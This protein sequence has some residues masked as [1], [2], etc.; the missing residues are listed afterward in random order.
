[1]ESAS[2]EGKLRKYLLGDVTP[3]EQGEIQDCLFSDPDLFDELLVAETELT[4]DY[5]FGNLSP[6]QRIQFEQYFLRAPERQLKL[7]T[8][9]SL[10]QYT[11]N[12]GKKRAVAHK[13]HRL[14]FFWR[15]LFLN[16]RI[17][18][19]ALVIVL[20][21]ILLWL[22]RDRQ[23]LKDRINEMRAQQDAPQQQDTRDPRQ[24]QIGEQAPDNETGKK[25]QDDENR[26]KE[27][28]Q[29][30]KQL[31][32]QP[33]DRH[34]VVGEK[35]SGSPNNQDKLIAKAEPDILW[36]DQTRGENRTN[37]VRLR[38]GA[39]HL[40][41]QLNLDEAKYPRYS[42]EFKNENDERLWGARGL[43]AQQTGDGKVLIVS[44]PA[45]LFTNGSYIVKVRGGKTEK[46]LVRVDSY[47]FRVVKE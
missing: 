17:A 5:L 45:N 28:D 9:Q 20:V 8:A 38:D 46:K 16:P 1:M 43:A 11:Y 23:V 47:Q 7:K 42:V 3:Q 6:Q 31:H 12:A 10:K 40:L 2:D 29:R 19:S 13:Q 4:D 27:S 41:I 22:L 34:S 36:P 35:A 15:W 25:A 39:K 24:L 30:G 37:L 21:A 33:P 26:V 44:P 32:K 14:A 18:I